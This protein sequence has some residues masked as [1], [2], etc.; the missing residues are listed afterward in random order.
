[1]LPFEYI[2]AGSLDQALAQLGA[3]GAM[4]VAG[5][6]DIL[7]L[8]QENVIAPTMLLDLNALPLRGIEAEGDGLRIGALTHLSDIA[9]DARIR[10]QYPV[11]ARALEET[12]SPQVRNMAT[13]GGNLLQRTRC[14]Y[15]RDASTPCNKRLPG[16]GCSARDGEN[17]MSAIFGASDACVAAYPGDMAN[18]LVVLDAT[19]TV[20]GPDGERTVPVETLHREPGDRPEDET[21]LQPGELITAIHLPASP[22]ARRSH[23]LKTRD[24][25]SF[26]WAL[27]SVALA[28][29]LGPDGR[30]I[31]GRVAAGGVGTRPWRLAAVEQRLVGQRLDAATAAAA[32]DLAVQ[33][34]APLR[35]NGF[36]IPLLRNCLERVL[37]DAGDAA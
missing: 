19:L 3:G 2:Q 5:G 12:A 7:Q 4:P 17:R 27:V 10:S 22:R 8:L 31:S 15:F 13:A 36:K 18:A 21:V 37:L 14:L 32:A 6:T 35:H 33:G 20:A 16:S 28:V 1:M 26:E 11:L 34:A 9:G 30:V 29:E 23:Y 25:A 24:R